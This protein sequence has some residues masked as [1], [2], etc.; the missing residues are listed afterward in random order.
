[1]YFICTCCS[2]VGYVD[3]IQLGMQGHEFANVGDIKPAAKDRPESE[4]WLVERWHI[5][6]DSFARVE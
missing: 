2:L 4:G 1:M 5:V 6:C 3:H